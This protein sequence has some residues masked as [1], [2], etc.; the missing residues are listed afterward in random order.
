MSTMLL[1][2][3]YQQLKIN[4]QL[5]FNSDWGFV[6]RFKKSMSK[7]IQSSLQNNGIEYYL[8]NKNRKEIM[9]L[10]P[11][12]PVQIHINKSEYR[13]IKMNTS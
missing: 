4:F 12:D 1:N 10:R 2:N 8:K 13:N 11:K 6:F 7:N 5:I 3:L 9:A